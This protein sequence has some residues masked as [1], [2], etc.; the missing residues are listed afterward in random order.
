MRKMN[1]LSG[2]NFTSDKASEIVLNR[3]MSEILGVGIGQTIEVATQGNKVYPLEVVGIVSNINVGQAF[4]PFLRAEEILGLKDEY[5]G[6]LTKISGSA[7]SLEKELHEKEFVGQVLVKEEA[8]ATAFKSIEEIEY[9]LNIY[10]LLGILVVITL[11]IT[12]Q[13]INILEREQEYAVLEAIGYSRFAMAK[14][15]FTEV[16]IISILAVIVSL[17]LSEV[18]GRI[19]R[20][21]F[22]QNAFLTLFPSRFPYYVNNIIPVLFLIGIVTLFS[23]KYIYKMQIAKIIRNKILG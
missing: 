2:S 1:L 6:I 22:A 21:R 8:K 14:M 16:F 17:P 5:S 10:R 9:F 15:I 4:V 11:V 20:Q 3:E 13:T 19:M 18:I 7:K 23:L 12:L